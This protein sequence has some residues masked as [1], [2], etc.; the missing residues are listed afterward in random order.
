MKDLL[1]ISTM[2]LI[3]IGLAATVTL[4]PILAWL[5]IVCSELSQGGAAWHATALALLITASML[6]IWAWRRRDRH[7]SMRHVCPSRDAGAK[8]AVHLPWAP[9]KTISDACRYRITMALR[10]RS[11]RRLP[12]RMECARKKPVRHSATRQASE[13]AKK[14]SWIPTPGD[15][16]TIRTRHFNTGKLS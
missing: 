5:L 7:R 14:P 16:F 4:W 6:T 8:P 11:T 1:N 2:D 10:L 13:P 15:R 3:L 9:H 12:Y